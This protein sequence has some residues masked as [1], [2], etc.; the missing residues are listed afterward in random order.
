MCMVSFV[1]DTYRDR[2]FPAT[3]NTPFIPTPVAPL[4]P[5]PTRE[6]F[7]A[8]KREV[9]EMKTVLA[10]AK[11]YDAEHGQPDCE[12][13]EKIALLRKMAEFVGVDLED[14]LGG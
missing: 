14:V 10:W 2:W 1:G 12:M 8:L 11:R 9:E 4:F 13:D 3:P 7:D 6:E 5:S